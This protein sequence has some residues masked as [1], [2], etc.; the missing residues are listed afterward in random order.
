MKSIAEFFD[1]SKELLD[2][3][4]NFV[5]KQLL[6]TGRLEIKKPMVQTNCSRNHRFSLSKYLGYSVK[7]IYVLILAHHNEHAHA[8]T[9]SPGAFETP[10]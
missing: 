6:F 5:D 10:E 4:S 7:Q 1:N 3:I 2:G 9:E 8:L